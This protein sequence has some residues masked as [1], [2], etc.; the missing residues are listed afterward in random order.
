MCT[1]I[2]IHMHGNTQRYVYVIY[3]SKANFLCEPNWKP[4]YDPPF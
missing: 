3:V 4:G 1:V 2:A